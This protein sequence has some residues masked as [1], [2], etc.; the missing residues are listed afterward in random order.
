MDALI[1]SGESDRLP[2]GLLNG[3]AMRSGASTELVS[4][5]QEWSVPGLEETDVV[6]SGSGSASAQAPG[7]P[8]SQSWYVDYHMQQKTFG[9]FENFY[10]LDG[11]REQNWLPAK[12]WTPAKVSETNST[13]TN[14]ERCLLKRAWENVEGGLNANKISRTTVIGAR[15]MKYYETYFKKKNSV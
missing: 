2:M 12:E 10:C 3:S 1:A 14:L 11:D 13:F 8:M 4:M 15:G 6:P 9:E 7:L 5:R